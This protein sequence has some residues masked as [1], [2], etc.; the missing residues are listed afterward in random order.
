M[1]NKI[2][3][4]DM[5]SPNLQSWRV[6]IAGLEAF[7]SGLMVVGVDNINS[8]GVPSI[9]NGSLL[10]INGGRYVCN[11]TDS[12][13]GTVASNAQN[14]IYAVVAADGLTVS[15][16]YSTVEPQWDPAKGGWYAEFNPGSQIS[17]VPN[18]HH[19]AIVKLFATGGKYNNKVILDSYNAMQMVN[20]RQPVQTSGGIAANTNYTVTDPATG[21]IHAFNY[22]T[23]QDREI[24]LAP[25]IYRYELK[26]GDG[27]QGGAC[28]TH[29]GVDNIEG[30]AGTDGG[31]GEIR[32]GS[33]VWHGGKIKVTVGA[34]GGDGGK[35]ADSV[36]GSTSPYS[37]N[38]GG[39]GGGLDSCIGEII[40]RGGKPGIGGKRTS[41]SFVNVMPGSP[42]GYGIGG[43]GSESFPT[44]INNWSP[45]GNIRPGGRGEGPKSST[46]GYA[47]LYRVG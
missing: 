44:H 8:D 40:A 12:I 26:G 31:A 13:G 39:G 47:R 38:G 28:G 24:D 34:D 37:G 21:K 14:Y 20:T 16:V 15:F 6:M 42:G 35:G 5:D 46:S 33:F 32:A 36:S 2:K 3:Y 25:G 22:N 11:S 10:D 19:R 43:N 1:T 29:P 18:A 27:G 9:L 30:G 4:P 23:I 41:S 45:D 17:S 7:T